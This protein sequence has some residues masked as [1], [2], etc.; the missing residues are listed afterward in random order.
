M[1][2]S[3]TFFR[4]NHVRIQSLSNKFASFRDTN[5]AS[6]SHWINLF[7]SRH[8]QLA[9]KIL[10][11]VFYVDQAK[12]LAAYQSTHQQLVNIHNDLSKVY[13][14]PYGHAG[15]SAQIMLYRYKI[16]N[17]L[18]GTS[19]ESHFINMSEIPG[20]IRLK[21]PII[22]FVDD[23]VGTGDDAAK[24]WTGKEEGKTL[25]RPALQ[26]IIPGNAKCYLSVAVGYDTGITTVQTKTSLT[27]LPWQIFTDQERVLSQNS[28]IFN[29]SEKQKILGYCTRTGCQFATGYGNTQAL[30]V[31]EHNCP[32]D[33]LSILW[34]ETPSWKGLFLRR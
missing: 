12:I 29:P 3:N 2:Q 6:I 4:R 23:F 5:Y 1:P 28:T 24:F 19:I 18:R 7:D 31:F 30:V 11:N 20:L 21:D 17:Q 32:N 15:S 8:G 13:F 14:A 27:V 9:I 16:A 33:S 26:D 25:K 34:C 10:E 22:V